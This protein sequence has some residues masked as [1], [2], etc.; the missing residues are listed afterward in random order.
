MTDNNHDSQGLVDYWWT[1]AIISDESYK[2]IQAACNFSSSETQPLCLSTVNSAV[3]SEF[4]N[5]DM[6]SIYSPRCARENASQSNSRTSPLSLDFGANSGQAPKSLP[7]LL[8][9]VGAHA[10]SVIKRCLGEH[11][12]LD[13]VEH[14]L[15]GCSQLMIRSRLAGYDPCSEYYSEK[16]YNQPE[17]Q[18]ALHANATGIRY[19]W[20]PCRCPVMFA[21]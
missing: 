5:I 2:A 8:S 10:S 13:I 19:P 6:Y 9:S 21:R 17:V 12:D 7:H 16:Y 14:L 15:T 20:T 11:V 4:G 18:H 1:H 3:E